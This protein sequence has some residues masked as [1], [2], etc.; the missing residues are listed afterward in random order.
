VGGVHDGLGIGE[1]VQCGDD[2]ALDP[3]AFVD[4]LDDRTQ[5]VRSARSGRDDVERGWVVAVIVD[6]HDDVE[7]TI[8]LDGRGDDDFLDAYVEEG[9]ELVHGS[10]LARALDHHVHAQFPPRRRSR[11]GDTA[12]ANAFAGDHQRVVGGAGLSVSASVNRVEGE[13]VRRDLTIPM[14]LV[15]VDELDVLGVPSGA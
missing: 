4:D 9:S 3:D 11:F 6:S 5:T 13:Q 8:I 2:A 10:E 12:E 14:Q 1:V 7:R 15:D